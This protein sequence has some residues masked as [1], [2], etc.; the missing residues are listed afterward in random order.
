MLFTIP[1]KIIPDFK[2]FIDLTFGSNSNILADFLGSKPGFSNS[3]II[4]SLTLGVAVAVKAKKGT[5]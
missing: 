3:L 4:S 1:G 5:F 2:S